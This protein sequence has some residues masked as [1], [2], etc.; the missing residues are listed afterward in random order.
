M[1]GRPLAPIRGTFLPMDRPDG[2]FPMEL[3]SGVCGN[4]HIE[5]LQS[6]NDSTTC[7][8]LT[9]KMFS[10][11][12]T[13]RQADRQTHK[14]PKQTDIPLHNYQIGIRILR[15]YEKLRR[16]HQEADSMG[17]LWVIFAF[18]LIFGN[19]PSFFFICS[20]IS[21]F[22]FFYIAYTLWTQYPQ[23]FPDGRG[24]LPGS[25][26]PLSGACTRF[27]FL[28]FFY[29]LEIILVFSDVR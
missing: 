18:F 6:F 29:F 27:R 13:N 3:L 14:R 16:Y 25:V 19:Y 5:K 1:L 7:N 9:I 11:K 12:E 4:L 21:F 10:K 8:L 2:P 17:W 20:T 22:V 23:V 15:K 26:R 28:Y 24:S